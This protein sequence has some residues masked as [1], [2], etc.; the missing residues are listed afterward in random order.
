MFLKNLLFV[1]TGQHSAD[2]YHQPR[3]TMLSMLATRHD[4]LEL[5]GRPSTPLCNGMIC[6]CVY[7]LCRG[8]LP[9]C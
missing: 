3:K 6:T 2:Y 7:V 5:S 1:V 8:I 4:I 9:L